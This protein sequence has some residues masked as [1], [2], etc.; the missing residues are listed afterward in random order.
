[1]NAFRI[2]ISNRDVMYLSDIK[3]YVSIRAAYVSVRVACVSVR[4]A[5]VSVRA[6]C[7][8]GNLSVWVHPSAN[9]FTTVCTLCDINS[10]PRVY[11]RTKYALEG[12]AGR[13]MSVKTG[14]QVIGQLIP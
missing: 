9:S 14:P 2:F 11:L 7:L 8:N 5:C 1:M 13:L 12:L 6:A 4:A 3:S 10:F